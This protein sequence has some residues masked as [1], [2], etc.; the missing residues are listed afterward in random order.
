MSLLLAGTAGL[1]FA[2]GTYLVLQRKLS[3]VI[4][5]IGLLG[6]GA[7]VLFVMAGRRGKA[8]LVGTGDPDGFADPL[9]QALVLTAIVI[10]F[11][12]TAFLLALAYR[13]WLLSEDDDV[14]DDIED[15]AVSRAHGLDP[16]LADEAALQEL[17]DA[18]LKVD[19]EPD[20]GTHPAARGGRDGAETS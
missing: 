13:S 12:V 4:I 1:L 17:V 3:R 14:A 18:E 6:H 5:G 10:S 8:P 2:I 9:P 16:E 11:G 15:R 20:D 19:V 7:N